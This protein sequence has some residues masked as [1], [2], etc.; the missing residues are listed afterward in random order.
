MSRPVLCECGNRADAEFQVWNGKHYVAVC[1]KCWY[2]PEAIAIEACVSFEVGG[3]NDSLEEKVRVECGFR[4]LEW[5]EELQA[6]VDKCYLEWYMEPAP[7][8]A[9]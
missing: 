3:D 9:P 4:A 8:D 6:F 1:W 7:E 5:T 2:S